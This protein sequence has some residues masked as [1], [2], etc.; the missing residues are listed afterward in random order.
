MLSRRT[1]SEVA[2][3]NDKD[4]RRAVRRLVE[5]E[6]GLLRSVGVVSEGGKERDAETRSLDSPGGGCETDEAS[7]SALSAR[8]TADARLT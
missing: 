5:D 3:G 8:G 7:T 4:L 6:I 2:S 1:A